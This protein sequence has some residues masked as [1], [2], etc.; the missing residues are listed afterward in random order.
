MDTILH[1]EHK[2]ILEEMRSDYFQQKAQEESDF[3]DV[4][5]VETIIEGTG[6]GDDDIE[7][8]FAFN[9]V[10]NL[11]N[12]LP[13]SSYSPKEVKRYCRLNCAWTPYSCN[14]L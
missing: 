10:L 9:Y 5:G 13:S 3:D 4:N 12:L 1:A 11:R 2:S 6:R 7:D 14:V 8:Q